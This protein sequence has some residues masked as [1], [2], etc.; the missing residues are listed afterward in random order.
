VSLTQPLEA[1]FDAAASH[2]DRDFSETLLGRLQ[3]GQVRSALRPLLAGRRRALD[4]GCGTGIDA[5]WLANQGLQVLATDQSMGMLDVAQRR[6]QLAEVQKRVDFQRLDLN[7]PN[8][9]LEH[10]HFDLVISNF[11]ALNCVQ[12]LSPLSAQLARVTEA[13]AQV[14]LVMISPI[15][16]WEI[17]WHL[18]RLKPRQAFRRFRSG[19]LANAGK[20]NLVPVWYPKASELANGFAAHFSVK[21]LRAIGL[22]VPPSYLA[23]WVDRFP[24]LFRGLDRLDGILAG[25]WP[26]NR[27][28]DH[29]LLVLE[30]KRAA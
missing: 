18:I 25:I 20:D 14:V 16:V 13:G 23:H 9:L 27:L 21:G 11:G 26:F 8:A 3:R 12:D 4:L 22:T 19:R 6:L 28:G 5:L 30:R 29:Y 15:C 1:P 17:V 10:D 24:Q 2:Y 7:D